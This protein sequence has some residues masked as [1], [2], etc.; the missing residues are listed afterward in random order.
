MIIDLHCDTISEIYC[1]RKQRE[2][3]LSENDLMVDINKLKK[4]D[5]MMQCFAMF[6][7][8]ENVKNPFEYVN[9]L[10]D[11]YEKEIQ[12]N[13]SQISFARSYEDIIRNKE[14]GKIS[15][16]LTIEE[17][18]AIE[19]NI[20]NLEHF[21]NRGVRM[22]SLTWNFENSIAYSNKKIINKD[23]DIELIS[24]TEKGLKPFGFDVVMRMEEM[25]MIVD[26]SHLSDAG[27]YDILDVMKVPF[28]ASHSNA[29]AICNHARN[30]NDDIIK[31]MANKGCIAGL[32]YYPGFLSS[33]FFTREKKAYIEDA[34]KMLKYMVNTGGS[35][36]AAL[37]S[38]YDGF[39]EKLEWGDAGG[40]QLLIDEMK[41]VGFTSRLIDNI[42]YKNALRI[43]KEVVG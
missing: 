18:E 19:G 3:Y 28:I 12:G 29:K 39:D 7:Y 25:G 6:T 23:G 37:G 41:K 17:G 30:L 21:Y 38:D 32:N 24:E 16:M 13:S 15:A 2:I 14:A 20:K 42:T 9:E 34:V 43:F 35:E 10:I 40:T 11:L 5:V 33:D 22:M 26:V 31:R 4:S 36:F 27:I 1:K 8:L